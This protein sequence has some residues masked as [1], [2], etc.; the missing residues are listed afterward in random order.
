MKA[1]QPIME[2]VEVCPHGYYCM[3][4][5]EYRSRNRIVKFMVV[6]K[7][8]VMIE[9][10]KAKLWDSITYFATTTKFINR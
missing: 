7:L 6:V 10:S 5:I 3:S 8:Q 1:A 9:E 4:Q 2:Q